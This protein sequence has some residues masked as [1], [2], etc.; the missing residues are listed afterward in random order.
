MHTLDKGK[1]ILNLIERY[2]DTLKASKFQ[3]SHALLEKIHEW[4]DLASRVKTLGVDLTMK[5]SCTGEFGQLSLKEEAAG[6]LRV[7]AIFDSVT[8]S[9]LAP[10][11]DSLFSLL[12]LIPNDGTFD[13]TASIYR[14][15]DKAKRY[16][17]A[18]SFDLS[19][20]TDRLPATLT[21]AIL[22]RVTG[23]SGLGKA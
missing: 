8:Q 19:A 7:F 1:P 23:V 14:S 18:Y 11:H 13:Q 20:A 22:E 9:V 10:L 6:K 12:R 4:Y 17:C 21:A 2:L 5:G 16:G 15:R 3:S